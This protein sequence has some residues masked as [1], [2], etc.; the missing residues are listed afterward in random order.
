MVLIFGMDCTLP[1]LFATQLFD[2]LGP[3]RALAY[4]QMDYHELHWTWVCKVPTLF[5]PSAART[6][7]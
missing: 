4:K 3:L 7:F 1:P 6:R 2:R 5:L